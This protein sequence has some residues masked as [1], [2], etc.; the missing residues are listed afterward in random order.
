MSPGVPSREQAAEC[1]VPG[2]LGIIVSQGYRLV[3]RLLYI[4]ADLLASCCP[5]TAT[6]SRF[7]R[8]K[9]FMSSRL[10]R[11]VTRQHTS[12]S[13]LRPP[14]QFSPW[15]ISQRPGLTFTPRFSG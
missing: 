12:L 4:D 13:P 8:K 5:G 1:G 7:E 11:N 6:H 3:V 10:P 2:G 15:I 14:T 9:A